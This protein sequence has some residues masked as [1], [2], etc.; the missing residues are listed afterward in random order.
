TFLR[1]LIPGAASTSYGI[2]CAQIAGLPESIIQRSYTL[3]NA[4]E[5]RAAVQH[6]EEEAAA[7]A[8][9]LSFFPPEASLSEAKP[10]AS[11]SK[12]R[13]LEAARYNAASDGKSS[14]KAEQVMER[15]KNADLI[16]M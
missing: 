2:Y 4:F 8:V 1:K 16:N 14:G 13:E 12:S 3:L 15:L 10:G 11:G 6:A 9:Q 5:A 7:A